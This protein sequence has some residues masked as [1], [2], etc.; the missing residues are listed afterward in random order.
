MGKHLACSTTAM[1]RAL[2]LAMRHGHEMPN[3]LPKKQNPATLPS[4]GC[5]AWSGCAG[6]K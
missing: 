5:P 3:D 4:A 1:L 6:W 2:V